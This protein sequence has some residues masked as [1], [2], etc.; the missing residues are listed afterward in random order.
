MIISLN[1]FLTVY[2]LE[3]IY[4]RDAVYDEIPIYKDT[5]ENIIKRWEFQRLR[6]I[7]Q[8]QLT[9]LVY[10][11]A[12]HTRFEHSIGVMHVASE[13]IDYLFDNI[14]DIDYLKEIAGVRLVSDQ[15]FKQMN[16]IV[17]RI[18][19]LLHD[20]GHGPLGHLFDQDVLRKIISRSDPGDYDFVVK[21]YCFS[22][23]IIS[24]MIYYY[25]LRETIKS[26]IK[27]AG[28]DKY[29]NEIM[30]WLDQIMIP[31]CNGDESINYND[32][33]KVEKTGYGY[34]LRM[35]IRDYLY[36]ADLL[37]YLI[38]DSRYTGAIEL[39]M[40]NRHRLMRHLQPIAREI[41]VDEIEKHDK[42]LAEELR[43]SIQTP[44]MLVIREKI[45]SDILRFLHARSLMYENVYLHPVIRAFGWSAVNILSHPTIYEELGLTRDLLLNAIQNIDKEERVQEFLNTY[46]DLTDH[47]LL[48]A[49]DIILKGKAGELS[50]KRDVEALFLNRKPY[51]ELLD[52]KVISSK[53]EMFASTDASLNIINLENRIREEVIKNVQWLNIPSLIKVNIS[54]VQV[55]PESSWLLQGRYIYTS[56]DGRYNLYTIEKFS[57]DYHLSNIGEVRLYIDRDLKH[58]IKKKVKE[59]FHSIITRETGLID[60]VKKAVSHI[61]VS[62]VTM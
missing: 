4:V 17:V 5:E 33:F 1:L 52:K 34:F 9:Y 28:F 16:R 14:D 49:K 6:Y 7:K 27:S 18:A 40:I 42:V 57:S 59:A 21:R 60:E 10:P 61:V 56:L 31:I 41:F 43:K 19:G 62:T 45:L 12:N 26:S 38:R 36:P 37:D 20:I 13:F 50:L 23:E 53:P 48:V 30:S 8:L 46:L 24:F 55:F 2:G 25:R 3:K 54:R 15:A 51:Y 32:V 39:G 22:H 35:I 11:S 29:I 58:E 44:V 47:V